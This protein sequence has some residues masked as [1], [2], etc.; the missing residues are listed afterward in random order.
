[1]KK[2]LRLIIDNLYFI[3]FS[4]KVQ[5]N[6]EGQKFYR[7]T[8]V[9]L[10]KNSKPSDII[11]ESNARIHGI[12]ISNNG[13]KIRI[14][15]FVHIAPNAKI[16]CVNSISIGAYTGIGSFV[17]IVDNN[18][19]PVNPYDRKIMRQTSEGSDK[20]S[21]VHSDSKPIVIGEN[22][23]VGEYARILKGVTIGEN[24]IVAANT[25][26]TKD[27]PPNSIVA[28]NPGKVVKT[29]IDKLPRKFI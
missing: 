20:R 10:I 25:V 27:V 8:K 21:W 4:K 26:V 12:L 15:K 14:G 28:G 24:S 19:H 13:G 2:I 23:W 7:T 18:Y 11:I 22:V 29:D 6:G 16:A 1:M 5:L 3:R 17:T 9:S